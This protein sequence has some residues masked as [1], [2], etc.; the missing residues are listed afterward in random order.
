MKELKKPQKPDRFPVL[1]LTGG[2]FAGNLKATLDGVEM[3]RVHRIEVTAD[4]NDVVRVKTY[5][6]IEI[7][8]E[9]ASDVE[10]AGWVASVSEIVIERI[11]DG[12]VKRRVP[13][14]QGR[15]AT[16]PA[17]LRDAAALLVRG[18]PDVPVQ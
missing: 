8:L 1:R 17:A 6:I 4:V 14:G 10:D 9:L 7:E 15:G 2:P 12:L 5:Q 11:G 3:E 13:V 16:Q 18:D